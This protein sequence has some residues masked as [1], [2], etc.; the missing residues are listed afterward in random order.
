MIVMN[1]MTRFVSEKDTEDMVSARFKT[2]NKD[3]LNWATMMELMG[4]TE[5]VFQGREVNRRI[6]M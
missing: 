4:M 1:V 2:R 3:I 5:N 6:R